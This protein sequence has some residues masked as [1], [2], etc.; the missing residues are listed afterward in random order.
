MGDEVLEVVGRRVGGEAALPHTEAIEEQAMN[1]SSPP[2]SRWRFQVPATFA[3]STS[4]MSAAVVLAISR[5]LSPAHDARGMDHALETGDLGEQR[6][7]RLAVREVDGDK[8]HPGAQ[9]LE[10]A[11][12]GALRRAGR[13]PPGEHQRPRPAGDEP[14]RDLPAEA[15]KTARHEVGAGGVE[16]ELGAR[17]RRGLEPATSRS[18]PRRAI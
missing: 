9:T 12:Q 8:L 4:S 7:H 1:S 5:H 18:S 3:A 13:S 10:I 17:R 14:A 11:G 15:A 6:R 2:A 16:A